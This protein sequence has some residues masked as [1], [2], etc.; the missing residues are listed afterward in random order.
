MNAELESQIILTLN[1]FKVN[2]MK[3]DRH[4]ERKVSV[5][6][7]EKVTS[8]L[9]L[10]HSKFWHFTNSDGVNNTGEAMQSFKLNSKF[11]NKQIQDISGHP[12]HVLNSL[13]RTNKFSPSS[14]IPFCKLGGNMSILGTEID[15]FPVPVCNKFTKTILEGQQC[16]KLDVNQYKDKLKENHKETKFGL[17]LYLDYNEERQ[18]ILEYNHENMLMLEESNDK[19]SKESLIYFGT[20]GF[21]YNK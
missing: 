18:T 17:T 15:E 19:E 9:S 20:L 10:E 12:V 5:I 14:F 3:L 6:L 11:F 16:Y 2:L 21:L 1:K 8:L 13:N 4:E 7:F